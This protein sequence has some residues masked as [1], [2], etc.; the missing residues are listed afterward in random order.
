VSAALAL[1]DDPHAP[2]RF[3][4]Q[5]SWEACTAQFFTHLQAPTPKAVRR[6]ARWRR[7]ISGVIL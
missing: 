3:A 7:K 5:F 6:L 2:R 4:E 1:P